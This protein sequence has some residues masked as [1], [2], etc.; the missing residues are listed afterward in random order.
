MD[1]DWISVEERL[2]EENGQYLVAWSLCKDYPLYYDIILWAKDIAKQYPF[3]YDEEYEN[4]EGGGW[5]VSS[6]DGDYENKCVEYWMELPKLPEE[7]E[8]K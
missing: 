2:P 6:P 8:Y 1:K 7:R 4:R 5:V 3:I